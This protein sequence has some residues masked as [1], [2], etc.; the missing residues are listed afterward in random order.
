MVDNGGFGLR[1]ITSESNK[2][3]SEVMSCSV[4]YLQESRNYVERRLNLNLIKT[5]ND[6]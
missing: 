1:P 2:E 3:D 5:N 4:K 6:C